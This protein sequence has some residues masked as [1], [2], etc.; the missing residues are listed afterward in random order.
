MPDEAVEIVQPLPIL[1]LG[2]EC[3]RDGVK[4]GAAPEYGEVFQ[5]A[6]LAIIEQFVAPGNGV[7]QGALAFVDVA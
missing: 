5:Q 6:L 3:R 7:A 2:S 1:R 4:R